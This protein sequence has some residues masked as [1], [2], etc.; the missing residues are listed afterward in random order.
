MTTTFFKKLAF[1]SLVCAALAV[2]ASGFVVPSS[3]S[4]KTIASVGENGFCKVG[5]T[6]ES[7]F[8][9]ASQTFTSLKAATDDQ[10]LHVFLDDMLAMSTF[11]YEFNSK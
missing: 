2:S 4:H 10:D 7:R 8:C 11:V 3:F 6:G 1:H 5:F 9:A